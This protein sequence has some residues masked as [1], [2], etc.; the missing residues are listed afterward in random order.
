MNKRSKCEVCGNGRL[1]I[2]LT[3]KMRSGK[4]TVADILRYN[5]DF[6]FPFSFADKLKNIAAQLFPVEVSQGKPRELYQTF[7]QKMREIDPD[8]WVKHLAKSVEFEEKRGDPYGIVIDDLRQPNEYE[9][10][11][12]NGF[13]IVRVNANE[14]T[15]LARA[16]KNGDVFS[17][18][19]LRHETEM[20][21]D[22]FEADFDIWN[23]GDD[24]AELERQVG[25][26]V[27]QGE[28]LIPLLLQTK[29][30]R[31]ARP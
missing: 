27:K 16:N 17:V 22:D 28:R 31:L 18:E 5:H 9:W 10:A 26:I 2:A 25:E 15:R 3:G 30:K 4:S 29:H 14:D 20:H 21:V 24:K 12:A 11:K 23:D 13:V 6:T 8:I 7:G 19:D 1:K